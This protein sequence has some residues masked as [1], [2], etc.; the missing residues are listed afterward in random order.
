MIVLGSPHPSC[1]F[2]GG[3]LFRT[4]FRCT[5][6]CVRNDAIDDVVDSKIILCNLCFVDGRGCRCGSMTPYR[7]QP[8]EGLVNLRT[9]IADM[10][11]SLLDEDGSGWL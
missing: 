10:L 7:L 8:L 11:D 3:E 4:A 2:C 1:S 9:R 5:G 6:S